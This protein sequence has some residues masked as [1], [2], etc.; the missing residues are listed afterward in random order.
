MTFT[1]RA[2]VTATQPPD[3]GMLVRSPGGGAIYRILEVTRL[4]RAGERIGKSRLRLVCARVKAA[5]VPTGATVHA[6]AWQA[7]APA[8]GRPLA[9]ATAAEPP[10][11]AVVAARVLAAKLQRQREEAARVGRVGREEHTPGNFGPALRRRAA[12]DRRGRL[13]RDADVVVVEAPDPKAPRRTL[14]RAMRVDP[15]LA[16][17]R[18]GGIGKREIDAAEDV[19]FQLECL[20]PSM[21][22]GYGLAVHVSIFDRVGIS[23][24]Q[25]AA[26][27]DLRRIEARLGRLWPPVLWVC[28]GGTVLG[29]AEYR[30][31]RL[32]TASEAIRDGLH[33]LADLLYGRKVAA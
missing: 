25:V 26:S 19:R 21:G 17:R 8:P 31:Q 13:L 32:A 5:E 1:L 24:A 29:W 6:W 30:R 16:L 14:T 28:M 23:S 15:L 4:H 2:S 10:P 9:A 18:T 33:E 27:R 3:V 22:G 11:R 7:P 20:T 12:R